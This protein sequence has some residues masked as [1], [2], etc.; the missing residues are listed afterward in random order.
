[1]RV[2]SQLS[3]LFLLTLS[4]LTK[5]NHPVTT[6]RHYKGHSNQAPVVLTICRRPDLSSLHFDSRQFYFRCGI[7]LQQ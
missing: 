3:K 1:M 2:L 7:L 6:P 4:L 5:I